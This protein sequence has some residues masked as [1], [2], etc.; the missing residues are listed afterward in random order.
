MAAKA[1]A[2]SQ[3]LEPDFE[4]YA[5]Q[6]IENAQMLANSFMSKGAYII[7]SGTDNHLLVLDVEKSYKLS[8]RACEMLLAKCGITVNRNSIPEDIH[9][10]W[11]TSGIRMGSPALTTRGLK[12]DQ[13]VEIVSIIHDLL[14]NAKS[15]YDKE[16]D[17]YSKVEVEIEEAII[18]NTK[19]RVKS[20]LA[21]A[22]GC[23]TF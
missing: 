23:K 8:G 6:V 14:S 11:Y 18:E 19:K 1:V 20:L 7:S 10:P 17:M 21:S 13:M 22:Q 15:L 9:G 4:K 16:K 5:K 2:F 12:K 3:C